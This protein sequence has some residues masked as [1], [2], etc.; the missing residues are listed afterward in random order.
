[1][2]PSH[3]NRMQSSTPHGRQE[4]AECCISVQLVDAAGWKRFYPREEPRY[5]EL[6]NTTTSGSARERN[7]GLRPACLRPDVQPGGRGGETAYEDTYRARAHSYTLT[8]ATQR[9]TRR[10][11]H[12]RQPHP[13]ARRDGVHYCRGQL[14]RIRDARCGR[15]WLVVEGLQ[16]HDRQDQGVWLQYDPHPVLR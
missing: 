14:V 4:P 2:S 5:E 12:E 16:I 6:W 10:V 8:Y 9:H 11:S 15:P 3:P 13:G 7:D 1:M